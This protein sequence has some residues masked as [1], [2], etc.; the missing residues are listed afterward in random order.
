[1]P[2]PLTTP[3]PDMAE[4]RRKIGRWWEKLMISDVVWYDDVMIIINVI[5]WSSCD[6]HDEKSWRCV[7]SDDALV[8]FLYDDDV[9]DQHEMPTSS[10]CRWRWRWC[11]WWWRRWWRQSFAAAAVDYSRGQGLSFKVLKQTLQPPN[12]ILKYSQI[13]SNILKYFQI[14][15]KYHPKN[16]KLPWHHS[17]KLSFLVDVFLLFWCEI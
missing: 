1:M 13:F 2:V 12:I 15:L 6:N 8:K 16:A 9:S 5:W 4:N 7:T 3:F 11:W 14:F 10:L 17:I